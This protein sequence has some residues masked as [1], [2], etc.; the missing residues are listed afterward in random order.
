MT[1]STVGFIAGRTARAAS[2]VGSLPLH[3]R[4]YAR[5]RRAIGGGLGWG[6]QRDARRLRAQRR[7]CT[8]SVAPPVPYREH[9]RRQ[10]HAG[11]A[12]SPCK[13]PFRG[14]CVVA[15]PVPYREHPRRQKHAGH[16]LRL[17]R[18]E[19]HLDESGRAGLAKS[20]AESAVKKE[21]PGTGPGLS[22]SRAVCDWWV[23]ILLVDRRRRQ[24]PV[25]VPVGADPRHED[26][27][28]TLEG[29]NAGRAGG[30][31]RTEAE[32]TCAAQA[33][34][35]CGNRATNHRA[36]WSR[37]RLSPAAGAVCSRRSP[38]RR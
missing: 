23:S 25:E 22:L 18:Q 6:S 34:V 9:P 27:V 35:D 15:P 31:G 7:T 37:Q 19:R 30:E 32:S 11:S 38:P 2:S 28:A 13:G 17:D 16:L 29:A 20:L 10:Q 1:A 5:L 14:R 33:A 3:Q 36:A 4:V 24:A 12:P 26:V 8:R 21:S